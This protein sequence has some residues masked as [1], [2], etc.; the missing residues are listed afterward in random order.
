[1]KNLITL[2]LLC[3]VSWFPQVK[4]KIVISG[5]N[6]PLSNA[7]VY[8]INKNIG[9]QTN[10]QGEF[11]ISGDIREG[12]L[13]VASYVGFTTVKISLIKSDFTQQ[14]LIFLTPAII[15][16]QSVLVEASVGIEGITP[17][18]FNQI[19]KQTIADNYT[20]QDIPKFLDELPSTSF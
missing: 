13:L 2:F 19:N 18:T 5:T 6:Q 16:A 12:D 15:P 14:L 10:K 9:A 8:F 3:T 17:L 1:M 11:S 20:L 4:G 7:N